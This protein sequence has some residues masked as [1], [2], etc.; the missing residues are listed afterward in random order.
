MVTTYDAALDYSGRHGWRVHPLHDVATGRC[1]CGTTCGRNAGKHPRLRE[2]QHVATTDTRT[3]RD[4]FHTWP[5]ANLGVA[6]GAGSGF[7]TLDI[8]ADEGLETLAALERQHGALP[9]TVTSITGRRGRH[10][11]FA[12]PGTH[13]ANA[14][15]LWAGIDVRADNGYILVPPSRTTGPYVWEIGHDPDDLPLAPVPAWLLARIRA[16][17]PNGVSRPPD[18]WAALVRGPIAE[19]ARNDSLARLAGY[20][21]RCRPAPHVVLELLRAVN[22]AR[23]RPLLSDHEV[24]RTVDSIARRELARTRARIC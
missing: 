19:G 4:W 20:L 22:E 1:S 23:C 9:E 15:R 7:V 5:T 12:H 21:L 3:I 18:E 10:L 2:W 6:T 11:L 14:V 24:E 8:E 17:R 16:D 13:V